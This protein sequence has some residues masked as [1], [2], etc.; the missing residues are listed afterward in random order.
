MEIKHKYWT[1]NIEIAKN[2][3]KRKDPKKSQQKKK[4]PKR[5]LKTIIKARKPRDSILK[6][7]GDSNSQPRT[8]YPEKLSFK[9]ENKD[10]SRSIKLRIY[11]QQIFMRNIACSDHCFYT[12]N[13]FIYDGKWVIVSV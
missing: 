4:I 13:S 6:E 11:Y 2:Q 7:L 10:N 5:D 8:V 12:M 1:D 9:N 3:R